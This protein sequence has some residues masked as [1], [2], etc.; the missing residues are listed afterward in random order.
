MNYKMTFEAQFADMTAQETRENYIVALELADKSDTVLYE[1]NF[2]TTKN[3]AEIVRIEPIKESDVFLMNNANKEYLATL[4]PAIAST[5]SEINKTQMQTIGLT[6]DK[7]PLIYATP[8]GYLMV[9]LKNAVSQSVN[10]SL[11]TM[12]GYKNKEN[13]TMNQ[14]N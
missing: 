12:E 8:I 13:E 10:E 9:S 7:N 14:M 2:E 3:F 5:F 1:Y 11:N 6:E 4:L